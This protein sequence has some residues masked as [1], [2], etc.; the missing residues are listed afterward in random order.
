M[1][2]QKLEFW[3]DFAS[4]YSYLSAMRIERSAINA[5]VEVVWKPF[6]LGPIFAA[7]GWN[8]S[9]FN[10]YQAKGRYMFRDMQRLAL[11]R[12]LDFQIPADFPQNSLA[13]ARIALVGADDG[14][15]AAFT[16][17]IYLAQ[18][19]EGLDIG[20]PATLASILGRLPVNLGL[21]PAKIAV[22]SSG[23]DI[24]A[25]LKLQTAEAAR[26]GLFGAPS[27]RTSDGELFW[28]DDRLDQAV[29]WAQSQGE[30]GDKKFG[31]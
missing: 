27:F 10:L 15:I 9:P 28:G 8:T 18:F 17:A 23:D 14:W 7:Q 31:P 24:K 11:A 20:K 29:T 26:L 19:A 22:R 12:G 2:A 16:R 25:R 21:D 4:T 30:H 5:G 13:A 3:Y 1:Q 6:L